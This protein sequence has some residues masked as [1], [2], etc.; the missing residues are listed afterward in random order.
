MT[1]ENNIIDN[2][3]LINELDKDLQENEVL[4]ENEN[5]EESLENNG[6]EI[7]KLKEMLARTQAD[8]NNFKM[9]SERDRQD[10][11]FFL[12]YDI[13]KKILPRIDDLERIIKNTKDEE[14][15]TSIYEAI[16]AMHKNY[17]KDLESMWVTSFESVWNEIDPDKHEVMTQI[18]SETPWVI[19]DEFEKGYMLWDR[20]LRVA[21]VI[22]WA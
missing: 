11:I 18:P 17:L 8:Y 10:M 3:E 7:E 12:K 16:L 22:V 14:K 2:E 5:Q 4:E 20:V 1:N 19:V 21:K 9:R 13:F 6:G 15:Q